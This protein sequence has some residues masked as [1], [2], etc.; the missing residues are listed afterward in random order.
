MKK[1]KSEI[2]DFK[3]PQDE[4]YLNLLCSDTNATR[5]LIK[6]EDYAYFVINCL[7]EAFKNDGNSIHAMRAFNIDGVL[8]T[9]RRH[10]LWKSYQKRSVIF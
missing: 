8:N 2:A 9:I 10:G 1:E 6:N 4:L 5:S 3:F 7:E